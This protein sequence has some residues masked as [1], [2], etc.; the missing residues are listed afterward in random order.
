VTNIPAPGLDRPD[1]IEL[2]GL[3]ALGTHGVLPEE[4]ERSQPFEV[5]IDLEVDL[6]RAGRSDDL[7]ETVDYG[8]VAG[9]VAAAVAGPHLDLLEALA[10]RIA[11]AVLH[12]AGSQGE[13]AGA[14]RAE[15]AAG[16]SDGYRVADPAAV[17]PAGLRVVSTPPPRVT[18]VTVAVRK[19]RP[20][21]AAD[22]GTAG[23]RIH[24]Y[25]DEL[26]PPAVSGSPAGDR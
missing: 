9:A 3:R 13:V 2:R 11:G 17:R 20:P 6:R 1:R 19:L 4:R 16:P 5:D 22:L 12:A 15:P 24:R 14:A 18:G 21:V 26:G 10:E 8:A 23:V 7:A 25:P